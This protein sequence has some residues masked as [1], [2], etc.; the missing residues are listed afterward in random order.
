[1]TLGY[2]LKRQGILF[3]TLNTK[4]IGNPADG[5][6][7]VVIAELFSGCGDDLFFSRYY[8]CDRTGE[9][10]VS[11]PPDDGLVR[12]PQHGRCFYS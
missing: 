9:K 11:H 12:E 2:V 4:G 1:M 5:D 3:G 6:H 10:P 7:T 8:L